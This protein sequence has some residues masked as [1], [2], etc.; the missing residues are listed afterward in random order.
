[1]MIAFKAVGA[2]LALVAA[3]YGAMEYHRRRSPAPPIFFT[4]NALLTSFSSPG[5]FKVALVGILNA[6]A[7]CIRGSALPP[8]A[9]TTTVVLDA[10]LLALLST[11]AAS[12][13]SP[14]SP[15]LS[16]TTAAADLPADLTPLPSTAADPPADFTFSLP[17]TAADLPAVHRSG[18]GSPVVAPNGDVELS[19]LGTPRPSPSPA[20]PTISRFSSLLPIPGSFPA[21]SQWGG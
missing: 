8:L 21:G 2:A 16:P 17:P 6:V 12:Q 1:M 7:D 15:S 10:H 13:P 4:T 3:V 11:A 9:A 19:S 18:L 5:S 20:S 14:V